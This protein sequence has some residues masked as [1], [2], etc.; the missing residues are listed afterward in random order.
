MGGF[1]M[2]PITWEYTPSIKTEHSMTTLFGQ[3][4]WQGYIW[5]LPGRRKILL[6]LRAQMKVTTSMTKLLELADK[7]TL[8]LS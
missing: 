2:R 7:L 1:C 8:P 3:G 5:S 6:T 4:K